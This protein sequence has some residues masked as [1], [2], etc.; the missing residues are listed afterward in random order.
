MCIDYNTPSADYWLIEIAGLETGLSAD[1]LRYP[2]MQHNH[3]M[4]RY[5][6]R[7]M[8]VASSFRHGGA[9]PFDPTALWG[10]WDSWAINTST[11]LGWW[12]DI[13]QGNGNV[14]VRCAEGTNDVKVTVFLKQG[15]AAMIVLAD[16]NEDELAVNCTLS[17]NWSALGLNQTTA[18][19]HAPKVPPFQLGSVVRDY[20]LGETISINV[21]AGGLLLILE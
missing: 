6:Y 3:G 5:H 21:S 7:G 17:Y 16:W 1:M 9:G 4:T 10:L 15:K 14:P 19:L 18:Q 12:E 11:L 8:L 2:T 20:K 13:E